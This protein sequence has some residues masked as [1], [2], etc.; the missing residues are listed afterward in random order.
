M[1]TPTQTTATTSSVLKVK[2]HVKAGGHP[3]SG[4]H[5]ETLARVQKPAPNLKVKT[6]VKAGGLQVQLNETLVRLPRPATGLKVKT[7]YSQQSI[8]FRSPRF[9]TMSTWVVFGRK[10]HPAAGPVQTVRPCVL[11]GCRP[12]R[13]AGAGPAAPKGRLNFLSAS[14]VT[15]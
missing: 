4:N 7:R 13:R 11:P 10:C 12:R 6:H 1:P 2:T 15:S 8:S 5:N 9:L 3:I 14:I